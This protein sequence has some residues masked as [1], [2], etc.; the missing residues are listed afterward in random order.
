MALYISLAVSFIVNLLL[1]WYVIRLLRKFLFISE[2]IADLYF[3]TRS[4]RIFVHSLYSMD[5]Y[6]GEPMVQ[7][8]IHKIKDVSEE[9][10]RFR[11]VFQYALD[12]ELEEELDDIEKAA[13]EA[14]RK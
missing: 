11:D 5:T 2:N 1:I 10:E 3:T 6:Y 4:F 12:E 8:L 9:L 13:Q 14:A 7:E